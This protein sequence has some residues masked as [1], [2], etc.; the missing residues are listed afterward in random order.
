[1]KTLYTVYGVFRVDTESTGHLWHLTH[2]AKSDA[3]ARFVKATG[4]GHNPQYMGIFVETAYRFSD[5]LVFR[6]R[7]MQHPHLVMKN[8][9]KKIVTKAVSHWVE[10]CMGMTV[11]KFCLKN[12]M[13]LDTK[14]NAKI[15]LTL[16]G[17]IR[18]MTNATFRWITF[19]F[20]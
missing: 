17:K 10:V 7:W 9:N 8:F 15:R 1:M 5:N 14:I 13:I 19:K 3:E 11:F 4:Q 20:C 12:E 16:N 6:F 2:W 18:K